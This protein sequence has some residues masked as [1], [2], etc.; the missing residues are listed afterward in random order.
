MNMP[1]QFQNLNDDDRRILFEFYG[2]YSARQWFDKA[3]VILNHPK[4]MKKTLEVYC[5]Y[6]PLLEMKEILSFTQKYSLG[7]EIIDLS[8]SDSARV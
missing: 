1:T 4:H 7:V 8:H 2:L 3:E 5:N 6:N